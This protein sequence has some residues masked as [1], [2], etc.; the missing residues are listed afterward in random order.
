MS[1]RKSY[2]RVVMAVQGNAPCLRVLITRLKVLIDQGSSTNVLYWSTFQKLGLPTSSLEECSE[3]LFRFIGER[4]EIRGIM[5]IEIVFGVGASARTIL[6]SYK[7]VNTWA[8]YNIVI[9]WSTLNRLRVAVS[10]PHL[11]MKYPIG[12]GV[13]VI[14][15]DKKITYR[16]YEKSLRVGRR[17]VDYEGPSNS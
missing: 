14:K 7:M 9:R 17:L 1:A 3:T 15:A 10:T 13:G 4:V 2:V 12:K 11:C 8:S 6:V 5:E 16:C